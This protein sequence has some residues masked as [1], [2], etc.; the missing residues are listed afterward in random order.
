MARTS[1]KLAA[2]F[3]IAV[4][5][6]ATAC[7][8][9]CDSTSSDDQTLT[10]FAAAS[11]QSTFTELADD[12]EAAHPGVTVTLSFAGSSDL[13]T[14]LSAG[15]PADVFASADTATLDRLVDEGLVHGDPVP[16]ATNTLIIAVPAGNPAGVEQFSD[17]ADPGTRVVLCAPQVPCGAAATQIQEAAGVTV[18]AVSEESSVTDV[19]GKVRSGEADAGLVYVTDVQAAAEEG[20][21]EGI[22]F[23]E[24]A[25]A[26]NT[27]PA[28]A[29]TD[30]NTDLASAFLDLLTSPAGQEV[31]TEA[32]FGSP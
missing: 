15:A 32:G 28:G 22:P 21:V 5:L 8:T 4:L 7:G 1:R 12:F 9:A 11:L 27:Y 30:G 6:S 2:G 14:Q 16:F 20:D 10:V 17:L 24:A 31:L 23:D 13:A 25:G 18:N 19:L 3:G 26:V 29:V